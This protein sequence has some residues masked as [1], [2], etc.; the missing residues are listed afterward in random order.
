MIHV[1]N[2]KI[3]AS[4]YDD[5]STELGFELKKEQLHYKQYGE[6]MGVPVTE[7]IVCSA[8]R[9]SVDD[10]FPYL[11]DGTTI[12]DYN[13]AKFIEQNNNCITV[14]E[15]HERVVTDASARMPDTNNTNSDLVSPVKLLTGSADDFF[16]DDILGEV[17]DDTTMGKKQ[18]FEYETP[19]K[20]SNELLRFQNTQTFLSPTTKELQKSI[21]KA[22]SSVKVV[23]NTH[24]LK[25][26]RRNILQSVDHILSHELV[27]ENSQAAEFVAEL[28]RKVQEIKE[29]FTKT[30]HSISGTMQG[31][32]SEL[33]FPAFERRKTKHVDK[34]FR[35]LSG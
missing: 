22:A 12:E 10:I 23:Y 7:D 4:H 14:R 5:D 31:N 16:S 13:Q 8:Q 34:R 18:L 21:E 3:Y 20:R 1:Q 15:W 2:W 24:E 9:P 30:V 35:G 27:M 6:Q 32:D 29:K 28:E 11:F 33:T 19:S 25:A 17:E 26:A